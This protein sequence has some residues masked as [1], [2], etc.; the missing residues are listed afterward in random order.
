MAERVG[1][2][3]TPCW[4]RIQKLASTGVIGRRVAVLDPQKIGMGLSVFIAIEAGDHTPEWLTRFAEAVTAMPEVMELCRMA[5]QVDYML[6]GDRVDAD[7][8]GKRA[9]EI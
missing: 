7:L 8:A 9:S 2:S 4:K 1:L 6:P 3:P 5:G